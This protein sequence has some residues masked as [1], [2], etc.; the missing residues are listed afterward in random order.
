MIPDLF[1]YL[2]EEPPWFRENLHALKTITRDKYHLHIICEEGTAHQN[3]HRCLEL[4]RRL[5]S[6]RIILMDD[7]MRILPPDPGW[8]G[9]L[10]RIFDEHPTVG[11]L[12]PIEIKEDRT[13]AVYLKDKQVA[14]SVVPPP[15]RSPWLPGYM[16]AFDLERTPDLYGDVNIP[17]ATGT[18]DLDLSLQ[19]RQAGYDC[20]AATSFA[21][22]HPWKPGASEHSKLDETRKRDEE[23]IKYMKGKWGSFYT[24][25]VA[26]RV[27]VL[28]RLSDDICRRY[29]E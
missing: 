11:Q 2:H 5:G 29:E 17:Y 10:M 6:R 22:S 14:L 21:V 20:I 15:F 4:A 25:A 26:S 9:D 3:I 16:M 1:L 8:L 24:Q 28:L 12:T 7:D 18:S 27:G 23:Q 13:L 19:V